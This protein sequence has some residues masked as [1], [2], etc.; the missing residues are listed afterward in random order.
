GGLYYLISRS[1][2][3]EFGGSLGVQLYLAQT[4]ALSFYAIAFARGMLSV[5]AMFNIVV[6]EIIIAAFALIAF[7]IIA[8]IGARFVVKLQYLI[9]GVIILSLVSIFLGQG[10]VVNQELMA[11]ATITFW[12]AFALFFPAVTGIDAGVGMSGNL[13]NAQRSLVR[14]TFTAI[15]ITMIVYVTLAMKLTSVA[16]LSLLFSNPHVA[17]EIAL[18]PGLVILGILLAT[19]SSALSYFM[20]SPR[21]LRALSDDGILPTR[22]KFLSKSIGQSS[23]PRVALIVSTVIAL[24]VVWYGSLDFVSIL[25]TIFFLN[26]YGWINGAA[27][28]EKLSSN[29]SYRPAFNSPLIISFYGF[30]ICYGIMWL[31][32]PWVMIISVLFQAFVFFL[33][34][35]T[36]TSIKLES[37]WD[38]VL[39][40][41]LRGVLNKIEKT[42]KSKKNWRP[43]IVAFGVKD[44]NRTTMFSLL[45]WIG[46]NRGIMKYYYLMGGKVEKNVRLRE[47]VEEDMKRYIKENDLDL[48]PR[49][50]ESSNFT[51]TV[52]TMLQSETI[53]NLPVNTALIDYDTC[54]DT[55]RLT[56]LAARLKKNV[57][58]LRNVSGF[59]DFKYVDVWWDNP[60]D[61]NLMMLIAYL[62]THSKVWKAHDAAIR[63]F[64][65]VRDEKEYATYWNKLHKLTADSRID[66]ISI[67]VIVEKRK[68]IPQ[69][70]KEKS[71][72]ADLVM[73]GMPHIKTKGFVNM[74]KEIE[75][76][77]E[78]LTTSMIVLANDKIDFRI[79]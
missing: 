35:R 73:M 53:G 30:I 50:I 59:S 28:F 6:D 23:E 79:N 74:S 27:F 69:L 2:G 29:P 56:S 39:F 68:K 62:I 41:F 1:L 55:E 70:I 4:V 34:Y 57:I 24:I 37:V 49:V 46:A 40:Q 19:S 3:S 60:D 48:F 18:F 76:Y 65:V 72:Y 12:V 61:G 26:V 45:D 54:Y 13:K 5:F 36:K 51:E 58:I 67:N 38:G 8:F 22:S 66:N 11:P 31:F 25:V 64:K 17:Q 10:T 63:L 47:H 32:N 77:T 15:I 44:V 33:L 43:T 42:E 78:G 21:T 75:K 7:A 71:H 9:F 52:E 16:P 14:G 20:S